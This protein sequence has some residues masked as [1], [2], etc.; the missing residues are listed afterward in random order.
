MI[1]HVSIQSFHYIFT[2]RV[3]KHWRTFHAERSCWADAVGLNESAG[4]LFDLRFHVVIVPWGCGL[5]C[6]IS[7]VSLFNDGFRCLEF[8][9]YPISHLC[10]QWSHKPSQSEQKENA[11]SV[12]KRKKNEAW[13]SPYHWVVEVSLGIRMSTLQS[14]I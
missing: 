11:V 6:D 8:F 2:Q 12:V 9:L 10:Y 1:S 13:L 7:G 14:Q 3:S 4:G 5:A